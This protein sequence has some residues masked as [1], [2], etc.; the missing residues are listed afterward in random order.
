[1]TTERR[2]RWKPNFSGRFMMR[3]AG[4]KESVV[5]GI[6]C[7]A[8]M[9]STLFWVMSG[10]AQEANPMLGWTFKGHPIVF[11]V[12]KCLACIPALVLAPRLAQSQR[13][14]TEWLLRIV[15]VSYIALYFG[16]AKF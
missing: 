14:F 10:Q 3:R 6:I 11:V 5:L 16:F 2:G 9:L 8:D 15:I 1:M 12:I 4:E 7:A 13:T